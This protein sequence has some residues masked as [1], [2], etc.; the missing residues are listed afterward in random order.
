M[1]KRQL[2]SRLSAEVTEPDYERVRRDLAAAVAV[3]YTRRRESFTAQ[4]PDVWACLLY[5]SRPSG[6]SW[7]TTIRPSSTTPTSPPPAG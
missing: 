2:L 1:Y 6:A 7:W 4:S 3:L 5:T